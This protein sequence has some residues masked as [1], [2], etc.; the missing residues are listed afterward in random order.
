MDLE[1]GF[2]GFSPEPFIYAA[3]EINAHTTLCD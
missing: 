2:M 1:V 3:D